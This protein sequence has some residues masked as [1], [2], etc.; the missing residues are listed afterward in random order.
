M[1]AAVAA[2]Q[3]QAK[4]ASRKRRRRTHAG[5]AADDCF[6]C[7]KKNLKCD[8]KR[9]YCSQCLEVG[10]ECSGYKTQLTWGVGVASRGKLRGLSLPIAKSPPVAGATK[11]S[12]S[13]SRSSSSTT[14]TP[15]SQWSGH[16]GH[17]RRS[18]RDELD[19]AADH[20]SSP[21]TPYYGYDYLGMAGPESAPP[22]TQGSWPNVQYPSSPLSLNDGPAYRKLGAHLAPIPI[23]SE[24]G[25]SSSLDSASDFDSYMSPY[26]RGDDMHY[27]HSPTLMYDSYQ[28]SPMPRS[29]AAIHIDPRPPTS[30]PSLVYAPSEPSSSV[31]SHM[32]TFEAQLSQRLRE[33]DSLSRM[34]TPVSASPDAEAASY[35]MQRNSP[36]TTTLQAFPSSMHTAP[37]MDLQDRF[38]HHHIKSLPRIA[39]TRPQFQSGHQYQSHPLYM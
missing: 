37:V 35:Y 24:P 2:Q 19:I 29:P 36:D 20:I 23:V 18:P 25:L 28:N 31:T 33:C 26:A 22:V 6:S 9:P 27:M 13:R 30:C 5:G 39:L 1:T 3:P 21:S 7:S 34:T 16:H 11:K 10:S 14:A 38:G 8:R 32:D 17:S 15:T 12:P 4:D